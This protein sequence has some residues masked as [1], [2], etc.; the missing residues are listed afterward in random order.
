MVL[1]SQSPSLSKVNEP[2][3]TPIPIPSGHAPHPHSQL[4]YLH[5]HW[6]APQGAPGHLQLQPVA[7]DGQDLADQHPKLLW[8]QAMTLLGKPRI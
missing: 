2:I 6:A 5:L 3:P 4:P 8:I 1:T 7:G